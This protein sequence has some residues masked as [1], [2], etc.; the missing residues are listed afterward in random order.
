M[1][2]FDLVVLDL[3]GTLLD[4]HREAPIRPAVVAEVQRVLRSGVGVTLATGRTWEYARHRADELGIRAPL[5]TGQ[6]ASLVESSSGKILRETHVA[7]ALAER[8]LERART[9]QEQLSLYFRQSDGRLR[10]TL[11]R[12]RRERVYYLHLLGPETEL[13]EPGPAWSEFTSMEL[14]KFVV[15]SHS[16]QDL[17]QWREWAGPQAQVSRT[18]PDLIEG[19]AAGIDKGAGLRALLEHCS[20]DST[21]VLAIGDQENDIPMFRVAGHAIAMGQAPEQVKAEADWI[22]PTFEE[23][24]VAA[25]LAHFFPAAGPAPGLAN[26]GP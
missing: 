22:A 10:I 15:F 24:G 26:E 7:R 17:G 5:V 18:H 23:D 1:S 25:A 16:S 13:I 11:N 8:V 21:R 19:T 2:A 4:P 20:V 14:L 6:G 9:G 3:D 12:Q